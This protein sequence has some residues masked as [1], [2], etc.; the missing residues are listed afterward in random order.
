MPEATLPTGVT[1][2]FEQTGLVR[3]EPLVLVNGLTMDTTSWDALAE[4]LGR[5]HA[6]IRYDGRGQGRSE[7]PEGPYLTVQ[8]AA[9][10]VGLLDHLGLER[11][12]LIG[13]SNGGLVSLVAAGELAGPTSDRIASV[14]VID[15]FA[16]VDTALRLIL[17]S[18]QRALDAG[19]P[20][21]RFDVATPWVWG[22][23]FLRDQE[24][25]LVSWRAAASATDPRR[26][27]AL[28]AGMAT[29]EADAGPALATLRCPVLALHGEDDVMTP[30]RHGRA[31]LR[32]AAD[33]RLATVPEAALGII[34]VVN[35]HME[36]AIRVISVERGHDPRDFTLFSFGGA[37]GMHAAYLARM[38]GMPRVLIPK[39][40]GILSAIGM[41][42]ADVIKDYSQTVMA[43]AEELSQSDVEAAFAPLEERGR[44]E[45]A[46]E[47][48][49]P[50]RI[51]L[52]RFFDMRYEGQS[53]EIVTPADGDFVENFH[54]LHERAYGYRNESRPV[55][56]VN[57]RLRA[58]GVPE[59][60]AFERAERGPEELPPDAIVDRREVV[61]DGEPLASLVLDRD[62]LVPGNRIHGPAVIVE[63]TSTLLVPPFASGRVDEYGNLVL[64]IE[65]DA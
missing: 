60:P 26:A 28:I 51:V 3:E 21:L 29:F 30:A 61:F 20:G 5:N 62:R 39:N 4:R 1:L 38:L 64:D 65:E 40:P 2:Y 22:Q 41:L 32:H 27:H 6:V 57:I 8:H 63:Y 34:R 35:S 48:V 31:L 36:R 17:D 59:K 44:E 37:G 50:A 12:H 42:M 23:A 19:G 49:D 15:S 18:W 25:A 33:G 14:T 53:W 56:A 54:A 47:G 46:A 7:K 16:E 58:R 43:R 13:L 55:Q 45:L 52:E 10:L 9:D 11:V 24:D